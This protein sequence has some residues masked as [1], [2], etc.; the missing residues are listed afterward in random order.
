MLL[1]SGA[2]LYAFDLVVTKTDETCTGNGALQFNVQNP[3]PGAAYSF[4]IF[5]HPNLISPIAVV[6]SNSFGGLQ[7]GTYRVVALENIGGTITPQFQDIE[8]ESIIIPITYAVAGTNA[9]CGPDGQISIT[10]TGGAASGFEILSGPI[11][12]PVQTSPVFNNVPAGVYQIR[13]FDT[14]GEGFVQNFTLFSD[15]PTINIAPGT[16]AS[17]ELPSCDTIAV[18]NTLTPSTNDHIPYP[19]TVQYT[20]FPPDGSTPITINTT[21]PNGSPESVDAEAV[22]PFYYNQ[23][24]NY[25]ITVTDPCGGVYTQ[26]NNVIDA[27]FF[28][29]I[30]PVNAPCQQFYLTT[31]AYF[32]VP[33]LTITFNQAPDGFDP[34]AFNAGHPGPFGAQVN[35]YGSDEQPV[36]FGLY[37]VTITDS[38]GRSASASYNLEEPT[39]LPDVIVNMTGYPGCQSLTKVEIEIAGFILVSAS[40]IEAPDDYPH[41]LPHDVTAM[42]IDNVIVLDPL[43]PGEYVIVILDDCGNEYTE[44]FE[45]PDGTTSSILASAWPGCGVGK[46]SMRMTATGRQITSVI[47]TEAPAGSEIAAGTDLSYNIEPASGVF[48]MADLNPGTYRF[49]I[50]DSCNTVHTQSVQIIGYAVTVND[51]SVTPHCGSFDL[52]LEHTANGVSPTFWLQMQDPITGN[53]LHPQTGAIYSEGEPLNP[54]NA[55]SIANYTATYNLGFI[56]TFRIIKTF[57]SF[58]NGSQG[59]GFKTCIETVNVFDFFDGFDITGIVRLTCDGQF[60][61]VE[62]QTNGVPPLTYK[63]KSKDGDTSFVINNG[64]DPVFTGLESATYEFEVQHACGHIRNIIVNIGQLPSIAQAPDPADIPS[65]TQCDDSLNDGLAMFDLTQNNPYVLGSYDPADYAISYHT[66]DADAQAGTNSLP[67]TATLATSTVYVRLRHNASSC[68][69]VTSFQVVVNSFPSVSFN[70]TYSVCEGESVVVNAPAGMD[71]YVWSDG[72]IGTQATF[73]SPG[74]YSLTVSLGS[75]SAEY[76]FTVT[77]ASPP[78]ITNLELS[79]WTDNMNS[80][81]VV[82]SNPQGSYT[83]SLDGINYQESSVFGGLFPGH[84]TVFVKSDACGITSQE[85]HLLMYP[86]FFTPNGDGHNDYWRVKFAE[87]EPGLKTFIFDRYGKLI[88]GFMPESP[89]WDGT[90]NGRMLPS[91]DY[92]FVVVRENGKEHRGHFSMKR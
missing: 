8:I 89:G 71:S 20:I 46:G 25:T 37:E 13:V 76:P 83:Y 31:S 12:R 55:I 40:I 77:P 91:T 33:P 10:V 69:D 18:S 84:Y 5:K 68:F 2:P 52:S 9:L 88:T 3:A 73:A 81:Q 6:T 34:V 66:S 72:Q 78:V 50:T 62:V 67:L 92:W 60:S 22:I 38:C 57:Q 65:I 64:N 7:S 43:A 15:S 49:D 39:T 44:P 11:V 70:T 51:H 45:V 54:N 29:S 86:R 26:T 16:P 19:L 14:C 82:L 58:A 85:V 1:A 21:I 90:L 87:A 27:Q 23:A 32:Y 35:D 17:V 56:G 4:Q 80:I 42:I 47:V 36:P 59:G 53:W 63:I 79:D 74:N 28:V 24:Y 75:C 30:G 61:D 41:E 48:F